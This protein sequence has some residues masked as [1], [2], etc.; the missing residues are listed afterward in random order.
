[1]PRGM[2]QAVPLDLLPVP[3]LLLDAGDRV[4][5][6]SP[7]ADALFRRPVAGLAAG[8][9]L[10][11]PAAGRATGRRAD[12]T[13]FPCDAAVSATPDGGRLV[14]LHELAE[15]RLV[16]EAQ[17]FFD[18]AFD[19]SP[20]GMALIDPDGEYVRVNDALCR[21]LGRTRG[22]LLGG[23]RDN[24]LTH[25]DDREADVAAAWQILR[26]ERSTFTTE[27]RFLR[28]DG[29]VVWVL[30]N[31][32]FLRDEAGTPLSWVGQFVDITERR[33][34]E[35]ALRRLAAS[36]P[37]T[38]LLNRR[39]FDVALEAAG[40]GAVVVLDLDGFKQVNDV[41]GHLAGDDVLIA[42][43]GAL[44][45]R[46]RRTDVVARIGGDEFAALLPGCDEAEALAVAEQVVETVAGL[47]LGVTASVGVA[48]GAETGSL[49]Q[50]ADRA[51][52]RAKAAGRDRAVLAA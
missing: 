6:A 35:R 47:G 24:L 51:M 39:A 4:R 19:S 5:A 21:L 49:L 8:E 10:L 48:A 31:L 45:D 40:P 37:L 17:R 32:V 52:Y 16:G 13:P 20:I 50:A 44:R 23:L 15:D 11:G 2:A 25:P 34:A 12:G 29:E 27:K 36:D 22:E 18:V 26:G 33:A 43:A 30:A 1:M 9:L 38:E 7:A 14:V 3:A 28:P 46:L 42:V 41:H